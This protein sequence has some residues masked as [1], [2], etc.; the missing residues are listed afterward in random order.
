MHSGGPDF[1]ML[2]P[3][4]P[5]VT[6]RTSILILLLIL[7]V[8]LAGYCIFRLA[9]GKS[10]RRIIRSRRRKRRERNGRRSE[11]DGQGR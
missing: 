1:K 6:P 8:L 9:G 7:T 5:V 3:G 4:F 10:L 11:P 2:T